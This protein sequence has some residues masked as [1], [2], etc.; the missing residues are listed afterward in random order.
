MSERI[1]AGSSLLV[2]AGRSSGNFPEYQKLT[3][4]TEV[5]EAEV[6]QAAQESGKPHPHSSICKAGLLNPLAC[7]RKL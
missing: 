6:S 2:S 7:F 3:S 4:E 5:G 1:W